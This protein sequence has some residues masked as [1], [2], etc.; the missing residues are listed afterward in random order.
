MEL[1]EFLG[2]E[3]NILSLGVSG[4]D[5]SSMEIRLRFKHWI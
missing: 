4:Q 5:K 3:S 2:K 1:K